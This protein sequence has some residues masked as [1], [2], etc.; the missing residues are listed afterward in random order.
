M[1][2]FT[3]ALRP[4]GLYLAVRR[5]LERDERDEFAVLFERACQV[6]CT[7]EP[8]WGAIADLQ[9]ARLAE[10]AGD[11][12]MAYMHLARQLG[13][14]RAATVVAG[15]PDAD[16]FAAALAA[17]GLGGTTRILVAEDVGVGVTHA[18]YE[19]VLR[20]V[21]PLAHTRTG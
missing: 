18:A 4:W 6:L 3:V 12:L 14:G 15:R 5:P 19:W 1:D 21:E 9:G 16:A 2:A 20:G 10:M 17:A 8:G 13:N 7:R 11:R